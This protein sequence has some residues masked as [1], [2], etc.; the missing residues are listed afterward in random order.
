MNVLR[1][2]STM[3]KTGVQRASIY[4][5]MKQGMLPKPIKL[6]VHSEGWIE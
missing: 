5:Y 3:G 6:G 1:I 4:L 2:K